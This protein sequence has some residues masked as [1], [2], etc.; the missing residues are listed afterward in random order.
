MTI[1]RSLSMVALLGIAQLVLS[2]PSRIP[3]KL[4]ASRNLF[5]DPPLVPIPSDPQ[6]FSGFVCVPPLSNDMIAERSMVSID[7]NRNPA[8]QRYLSNPSRLRQHYPYDITDPPYKGSGSQQCP[9]THHASTDIFF[10]LSY[11]SHD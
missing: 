5:P 2:T 9:C 6:L 10:M 1:K 7:G 3:D 11:I 8:T 4:P